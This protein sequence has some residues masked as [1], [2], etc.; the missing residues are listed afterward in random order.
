MPNGHLFDLAG[1]MQARVRVSLRRLTF[2]P[3]VAILR[4]MDPVSMLSIAIK[5]A[6]L[7]VCL[8][9][10]AAMGWAAAGM[11]TEDRDPTADGR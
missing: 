8:W 6:V 5:V 11:V 1:E 2:A 4:G 3:G 9:W 7:V 10:L